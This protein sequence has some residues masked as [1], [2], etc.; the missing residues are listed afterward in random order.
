MKRA[1]STA[2]AAVVITGGSIVAAAPANAAV[3]ACDQNGTY[4]AIINK[5]TVWKATNVHSDWARPGVTISYA[6]NKTGSWTA[7]GT[8]TVGA[9]A[10]V[11]LAKASTSFSVSLAKT[12]SKSDTWTYSAT[13]QSK[14]GKT[15]GRLMMHHEAKSF[16]AHK[17]RVFTGPGGA[18]KTE[19]IYK[20]PGTLPVKKNSNLWGI[21]YS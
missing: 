5:K 4:I 18:C 7:T 14:P 9:E 2:L 17:Y 19:T 1:L 12:W 16:T 13:V 3:Q 11:I 15:K 8:A 6:K 21:Q 20:K 10:G